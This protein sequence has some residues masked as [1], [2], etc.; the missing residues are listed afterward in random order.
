MKKFALLLVFLGVSFFLINCSSDSNDDGGSSNT[1]P[2]QVTITYKVIGI[3]TSTATLVTYKNET[4]GITNVENVSLPYTKTITRT[5]NKNDDASLGYGTNT[6]T[7]VRLE[8]S[9]N[10][11]V[12]K[13]QDFNSTSGALVYLFQ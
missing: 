13:S 5:V 3:N 2:K 8:I 4:G 12:Q 10:N 6:T 11:T 9:V 7:S 1:Y